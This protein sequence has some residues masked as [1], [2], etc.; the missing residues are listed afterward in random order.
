ME[1]DMKKYINRVECIVD[2][3]CISSNIDSI[4]AGLPS[5][6]KV[7]A[8]VKADAYGHGA[9][10]VAEYLKEKV[11]FF[12]V[13]TAGEAMELREAGISNPI[14]ILGYVWPE[15]YGELI[16]NEIRIPI[17]KEK[18]AR[19]LA[20]AAESI[21]KEAYVHIKV[22]TGMNRIGFRPDE[23][24]AAIVRDICR[25]AW[26]KTEGI[27]THFARADEE[28]K[29]SAKGQL[30]VFKDFISAV[31]KDGIR[32]PIHHCA[33]SAA[34]MELPDAAMDMVRLGIAMYGLYPSDEV[35]RRIRLLPAM[36]LTSTVV[37]IKDVPEGSGISYNHTHILDKPC[38][39]ATIPVGYGDGYPR[40]LSDKGSVLIRGQRAR[41][42]GRICMDQL[43][44]D[45]T[46]IPDAEEGDRVVL[47]GSDG[48]GTIP[49]EELS[50]LCG[51]FN[52]EFMCRLS[53]RI[54]R[55]YIK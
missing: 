29:T 45:V 38:R 16:R 33:N 7:C 37:F 13:A 47:V 3:R 30:R 39:V 8:V 49:V 11:D 12:A 6:T 2:L 17:F 41:I 50:A 34:S 25:T 9:K 32:I 43:M 40:L 46:D 35:S 24:S 48:G 1:A 54:P 42:L 53:L 4:K 55:I 52:Y 36:S 44:V 21:G 5:G 18:D 23:A 14:L 27:F 19:K 31:E 51:I 22:D 20:A 10:A 15:D 26:L 28:D